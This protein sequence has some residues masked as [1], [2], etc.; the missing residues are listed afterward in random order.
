MLPIGKRIS[1]LRF[2]SLQRIW[3]MSVWVF[4]EAYVQANILSIFHNH[5]SGI[6]PAGV[7]INRQFHLRFKMSAT[8][9]SLLQ[10]R[11]EQEEMQKVIYVWISTEHLETETFPSQEDVWI[12]KWH[13][14]DRYPDPES[15]GTA[16]CRRLTWWR[17]GGWRWGGFVE[18]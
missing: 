4:V 3:L 8:S 17:G 9:S 14:S 10:A 11:P 5:V 18:G 13:K 16:R 1:M 12:I 7:K 2:Y 15:T 6:D